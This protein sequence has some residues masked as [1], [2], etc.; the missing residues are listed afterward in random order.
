MDIITQSLNAGKAGTSSSLLLPNLTSPAPATN[1]RKVKRGTAPGDAYRQNAKA[2]ADIVAILKSMDLF[3]CAEG[4]LLE[5]CGKDFITTMSNKC[6]KILDSFPTNRCGLAYCP[7]CNIRRRNRELK[8]VKPKFD[9][10]LREN[11]ALRPYFLTLT[12]RDRMTQRDANKYLKKQ[13]AKLRRQQFWKAVK[14]GY[15]RI[16]FTVV[17]DGWHSHIHAVILSEQILE[18]DKIQTAWSKLTCGSYI[19]DIRPINLDELDTVL[20]Y[21]FKP[22]DLT[23]MT[24][25]QALEMISSSAQRTGETF[26]IVRRSKAEP[27]TETDTPA[28]PKVG[29]KCDC[30]DPDCRIVQVVFT[31][32]ELITLLDYQTPLAVPLPRAKPRYVH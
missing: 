30:G 32:D 11:P 10:V 19:T 14:G 25:E 3:T 29:D 1:L 2:K 20:G 27:A 8:S 24:K 18:V 5:L 15:Y 28:K 22:A 9:E 7:D 13:F 6:G 16:E 17:F 31:R 21:A 23:K 26:G 4:E 12:L